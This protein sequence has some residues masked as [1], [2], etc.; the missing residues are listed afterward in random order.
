LGIWFSISVYSPAQG[1]F[2]AVFD[3]ITERKRAEEMIRQLNL[4]LEERVQQRTAQLEAAN[5]ELEAFS[6]SVSHDLRAPLRAVDGFAG[7]LAEDHAG[8]L[9]EEGRRVVGVIR[10]EA[11][12]MGQLIDDLLAFSRVSRGPM[13]SEEIDMVSLARTIF[14]E[15][16]A[17]AA[18]RKIRLKINPLLPAR[19]D[20]SLIRQVLANLL[21]NAL[22][23][24]APRAEAEIELGSRAEGN[25][26]VYWIKDNGVGFDP[27]YAGK[28]F[29]I[30]QRLHSEDEFKGTGVG[31]AL[32][33]RI[34]LCHGGR[35]WAESKLNEGAVFYFTLRGNEESTM[36]TEK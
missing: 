15:C 11:A 22:K 10:R 28:L 6:Y 24:T 14:G 21:S 2:V 9:D 13:R 1:H 33:R 18:D 4:E 20:P 31:L 36:K 34:V 32:V 35:V 19:G 23:Y 3:N 29:G 7:V 26:N 30:F 25:E 27:R 12:R 5:K 16:A 17:G 8:Q